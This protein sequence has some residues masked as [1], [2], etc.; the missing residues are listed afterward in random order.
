[1]AQQ[2]VLTTIDG[3][4]ATLTINRP[5]KLN[6][7]NADVRRE[8]VAALKE[9]AANEE[10]RVVV[11]T[12]AGEKAFVA[13]ADIAEFEARTAVEQFRV[14]KG[15]GMVEAV[16]A[17]PKPVIAAINGFC[18]GG[19]SALPISSCTRARWWAPRK[20]CESAWWTRSFR[21]TS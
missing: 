21:R 19:G 7:L 5:D 16:D 13:G 9:L 6:A 2:S 10:V 15:F 11:V 20:P 3:R 1:M 17:F 14:M 4:V 12:G 18:L 8:F